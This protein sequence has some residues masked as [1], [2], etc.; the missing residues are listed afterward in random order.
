MK[1]IIYTYVD[2][3][4]QEHLSI[5]SPQKFRTTIKTCKQLINCIAIQHTQQDREYYCSLSADEL[6][7]ALNKFMYWN[8][9]ELF[10]PN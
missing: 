2:F 7:Y 10:Y 1:S 3:E 9:K 6:C 8:Q 5:S 4:N